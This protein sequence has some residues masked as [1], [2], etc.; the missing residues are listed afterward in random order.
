MLSKQNSLVRQWT[1]LNAPFASNSN[2]GPTEGPRWIIDWKGPLFVSAVHA[3]DH[4]RNGAWKNTDAGTG[5]LAM[6]LSNVVG[7][8]R[9][10]VTRSVPMMGDANWD[11]YHP[12]KAQLEKLEHVGESSVYIDL[13]GMKD[14]QGADVIIGCGKG[15]PASI[16]LGQRV[17]AHLED[18]RIATDPD[19][20][21]RGFGA[22]K[23]GTMTSWAQRQGATAIQIEISRSYRAAQSADKLKERLITGLV[24]ALLDEQTRLAS[25]PAGFTVSVA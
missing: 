12:L 20:G 2:R 19:G 23:P 22:T 3:V 4:E 11:E 7:C 1:E 18:A 13:H 21:K 6:A 10:A 15:S 17:A 8:S 25:I 14:G 24:N 9:V 5:G 16:A